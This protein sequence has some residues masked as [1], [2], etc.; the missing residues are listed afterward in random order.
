MKKIFP[1]VS[2]REHYRNKE[3]FLWCPDRRFKD[4][5][6][7]FEKANGIELADPIIIPGGAKVLVTPNDPRDREFVL[8]QIEILKGHGFDTLYVMAHNE[9]AACEGNNDRLFY[10]SMLQSAG[11]VVRGRFPDLRVRLLFADFDGLYEVE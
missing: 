8:E 3:A 1:F 10:E 2:S 6:E 7:A 5:R 11:K 4:L 9:C